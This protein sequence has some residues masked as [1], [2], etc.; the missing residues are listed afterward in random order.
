MES[1]RLALLQRSENI[2]QDRH[3]FWQGRA[4]Q[5]SWL[6]SECHTPSFWRAAWIRVNCRF[7]PWVPCNIRRKD[8]KCKQIESKSK[9]GQQ[10][11]RR[12]ILF[13]R[14][15]SQKW[16]GFKGGRGIVMRKSRLNRLLGY[17]PLWSDQNCYNSANFATVWLETGFLPFQKFSEVIVSR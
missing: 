3:C 14:Q 7:C 11:E 8:Y 9:H 6:P 4:G 10:K 12:T 2:S 1:W 13:S 17:I 15:D 16:P 5:C